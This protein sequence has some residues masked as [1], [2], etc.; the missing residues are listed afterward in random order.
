MIAKHKFLHFI[1][2]TKLSEALNNQQEPKS[3]PKFYSP[4]SSSGYCF[5][6]LFQFSFV[7]YQKFAIFVR[8]KSLMFAFSFCFTRINK[9]FST[10]FAIVLDI[11]HQNPRIARQTSK[12]KHLKRIWASKSYL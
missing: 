1:M 10:R 12:H 3:I 5:K 11:M 9:H 7:L 8:E 2:R 6:A 4:P